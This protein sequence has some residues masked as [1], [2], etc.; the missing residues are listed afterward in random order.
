MTDNKPEASV[1][2]KT[3]EFT[4]GQT[5]ILKMLRLGAWTAAF[6]AMMYGMHF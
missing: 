1:E 4:P 6:V 5:I 3:S 2:D